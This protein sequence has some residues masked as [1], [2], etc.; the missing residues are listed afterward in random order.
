MHRFTLILVALLSWSG[1]QNSFGDE[2]RGVWEHAGTG[3]FP[4]DWERSAKLL[5]DNGFNMVITNMLT[6]GYA[7]YPSDVLPHSA[8]FEKYGDQIQQCCDACKKHGLEV[9]VWKVFFNMM[10]P[11]KEWAEKMRRENRTQVSVD[12]KPESWL[13]PSNPENRKMELDAML[14]VARKYPVAGLHFD[15]IRYPDD[16]HCYC[17]GCRERFESQSGQKVA[18]WPADCSSGARKEEYNQWRCQQISSLVETVSRE[19]H[20]IR[21]DIKMSAAVFPLFPSCRQT[22]AQNWPAW[23]KAGY[24]DFLCPMDYTP[25]E[26]RFEAIVAMQLK[27]IDGRIPLYPGIGAT[28]TG[29]T[30]TKDQ[31]IGQINKAKATGAA[32]FTI[33]NFDANTAKTIIPFVGPTK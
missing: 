9:H 15:Y 26:D 32:G 10:G 8:A 17:D 31:V 30:L 25:G 33:F 7:H 16:K 12:G 4:G 19:A 11:S 20:K 3:A 14:E 1:L 6:S 22:V 21:P 13:C 29:M 24:L 23:V 27:L 5:A 18:D 2:K 28:A